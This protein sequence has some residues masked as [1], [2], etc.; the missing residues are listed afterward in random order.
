MKHPLPALAALLLPLAPAAAADYDVVVYGGTSAGVI[1][2]VQ[3]KAMGKSV[4]LVGQDRHLGGL[5]LV[6][7]QQN[8]DRI[9]R[10]REGQSEKDQGGEEKA[11]DLPTRLQLIIV[12]KIAPPALPA[13]GFRAGQVRKIVAARRISR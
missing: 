1:A 6:V 13:S 5:E 12:R 10:R 9:G 4:V 3:A 2:A 7:A 8:D 11:H